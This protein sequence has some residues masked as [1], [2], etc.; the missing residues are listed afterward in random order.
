MKVY[1]LIQEDRHYETDVD[2]FAD[3]DEAIQTASARI[4][5]DVNR[6]CKSTPKTIEEIVA[7]GIARAETLGGDYVWH[8]NAYDDGPTFTLREKDVIK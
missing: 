2:V 8:I 5:R 6:W 1:V 7:Q 4:E 3:K